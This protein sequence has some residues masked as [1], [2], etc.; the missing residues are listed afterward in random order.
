MINLSSIFSETVSSLKKK[1]PFQPDIAIILGSGL[2]DFASSLD[3]KVS[4]ATSDLPNYPASTVAGHQGK[5]HFAE[6]AGKK[7]ILFQGRIHFYEGYELYQCLLPVH[8]CSEL[9][10]KNILFTNAA[11][12][13][14]RNFSPGDLMLLTSF[15]SLFLKKELSEVMGISNFDAKN[16]FL[17]CPSQK[18]N[19]TIKQSALEEK[20]PLKEGTYWYSK[21]PSYETPAE[22]EMMHKFGTDAVGMSTVHEAVYAVSRG[23]KCAGIS[24]ITNFAAGI[25]N[26]KL[27]HEEVTETANRVKGNFERLIKKF[28]EIIAV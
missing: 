8:L 27:S 4:V 9:G 1:A 11:G 6:Y 24:C 14:N 25:S 2:G 19:E 22:I 13:I 23:M 5:I 20:I 10:C 7:I 26:Q 18:L 3:L 12:G 16:N 15:N 21:G 28:I 17:D